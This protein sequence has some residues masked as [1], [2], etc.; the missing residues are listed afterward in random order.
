MVTLFLGG[1]SSV[2][3]FLISF[4]HFFLVET[5]GLSELVTVS[6]SGLSMELAARD[7]DSGF[8]LMCVCDHI[9]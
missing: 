4:C 1:I 5:H 6:R 9:I 3:R 2:F 8:P 7:G